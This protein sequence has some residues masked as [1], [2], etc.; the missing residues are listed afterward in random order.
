MLEGQRGESK[1]W[2]CV[3][4]L[5]SNCRVYFDSS[6]F[7]PKILGCCQMAK[8]SGSITKNR[9][10]VD[11][12]VGISGYL[13]ISK[14]PDLNT[15]AS[16]IWDTFQPSQILPRPPSGI[17]IHSCRRR[18]QHPTT[19]LH[20]LQNHAFHIV[21]SAIDVYYGML[22][23]LRQNHSGRCGSGMEHGLCKVFLCRSTLK[24]KG[25]MIP[26]L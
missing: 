22:V 23:T 4:V 20:Y 17:S 18:F 8:A 21:Y 5:P 26:F 10:C 6:V 16:T 3:G 13:L 25:N 19:G 12:K 14:L 15:E 1:T 24:T 7:T 2:L 9:L 11:W